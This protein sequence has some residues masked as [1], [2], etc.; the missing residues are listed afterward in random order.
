MAR[1]KYRIRF[2]KGGDLRLLSHHDL[3]RCFE[4]MLRRAALPVHCSEG[5]NPKPR[6]VFALSL[7]LGIIGRREILEIELDEDIAA[8]ELQRRLAEQAPAGLEIL[9]VERTESKVAAHVVRVCY[10]VALPADARAADLDERV[11][12]LL[13]AKSLPVERLRP[14]QRMLDIRPFIR[15]LCVRDEALEID[16]WVT[17][18]GAA[19]PEEVLGLLGLTPILEQ[20]AVL[21]RT[22]LVL[23][24]EEDDT[25]AQAAV[26]P[27]L[28]AAA[29]TD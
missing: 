20:G 22:N 8:E 3:M 29:P 16:L 1:Q 5:F 19:R 15:Q 13:A 23:Q 28:V 26:A 21:E 7:A 18:R 25:P 2:R 11:Q 17:P 10:R 27:A 14:K 9:Q 24:D 6:M 4:R 12:A